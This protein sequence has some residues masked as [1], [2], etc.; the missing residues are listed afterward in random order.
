MP[1]SLYAQITPCPN[2][3]VP[4]S[5]CPSPDPLLE[6]HPALPVRVRVLLPRRPRAPQHLFSG[7]G[8][9]RPVDLRELMRAARA[10]LRLVSLVGV[11]VRRRAPGARRGRH[12]LA[13]PLLQRRRCR[14]VLPL[15]R[16]G[17]HTARA[18]FPV[19]R[20][21]RLLR[22]LAQVDPRCL[23]VVGMVVCGVFS[24]LVWDVILR[25]ERASESRS[26]QDSWPSL[27]FSRTLASSVRPVGRPFHLRFDKPQSAPRS[28]PGNLCLCMGRST[29]LSAPSKHS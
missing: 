9:R 25:E 8:H 12:L 6:R 24:T 17:D 14:V 13:A 19:L 15:V 10:H 29:A 1:R 20:V 26:R 23:Y 4:R 16:R 27:V 3:S 2:H 7:I 18:G 11:L 5:F 21:E 22:L 28:L